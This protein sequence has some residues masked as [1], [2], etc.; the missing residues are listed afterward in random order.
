[1]Y[2]A[3]KKHVAQISSSQRLTSFKKKT[4]IFDVVAGNEETAHVAQHRT[5]EGL[6]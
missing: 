2:M 5:P 6:K 3:G 4:E 1:M